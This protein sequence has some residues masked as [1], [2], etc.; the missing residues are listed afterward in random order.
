MQKIVK[1][2]VGLVLVCSL[3][4]TSV[5]PVN[6]AT[7]PLLHASK[8]AIF[9][10]LETCN[11]CHVEENGRVG[12]T[13]TVLTVKDTNLYLVPIQDDF[14]VLPEV[15]SL[16]LPIFPGMSFE[17]ARTY[18]LVD[19]QGN[20]SSYG[21][22]ANTYGGKFLGILRMSSNT[23]MTTVDYVKKNVR[24]SPVVTYIAGANDIYPN[25]VE[26]ILLALEHLSTY[27]DQRHGFKTDKYISTLR[28]F[29]FYSYEDFQEYKIGALATGI[30]APAGGVCAPATGLASL[31]YLT[32]GAKIV[33]IVHHD[34]EHLYFQGPFSPPAGTVDSGISI[35]P[36]GSFEELG[37][38]FPDSGYFRVDTQV[39]PSGVVYAKTDPQGLQGLSDSVLIYS[40]SYSL[41]PLPEQAEIIA[42]QLA[43]FQQFRSSA[44]AKSL[45]E[46]SQAIPE[47]I[48]T[49]GFLLSNIQKL[50]IGPD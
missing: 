9:P 17:I 40:I 46:A 42:D 4:W 30:S 45:L 36:D 23:R 33:D 18:K 38:A 1:F 43:V 20:A 3:L 22:L 32:E 34:Q 50:Y 19:K 13:G 8:D 47:P 6:A 27:Q 11:D 44:H 35:R 5:L 15:E 14:S 49:S 28:A 7:I 37:F 24:L 48:Q 21:L 26:N 25:K 12:L 16:K 39:L 41:N 10:D 29:G 31:A 2:L